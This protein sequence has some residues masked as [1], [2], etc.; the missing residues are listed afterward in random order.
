M[1]PHSH[2]GPFPDVEDVSFP[3]LKRLHNLTSY[4]DNDDSPLFYRQLTANKRQKSIH[5]G[6]MHRF[7][8]IINKL[9]SEIT[10]L[11]KGFAY[12]DKLYSWDYVTYNFDLV[13]REMGL[14]LKMGMVNY[15]YT[16]YVSRTIEKC[17]NDLNDLISWG[18]DGFFFVDKYHDWESYDDF[19]K[20]IKNS[21]G[22]DVAL[23]LV[24]EKG[25]DDD[26]DDESTSADGDDDES[27]SADGGDDDDDDESASADDPGFNVSPCVAV[28]AEQ[29]F[30]SDIAFQ[31]FDATHH[32]C[33]CSCDLV[34]N[35]PYETII[36]TGR[37][38]RSCGVR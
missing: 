25:H 23:G 28:A 26:D 24:L 32:H 27:T 14:T 31:A 38:H 29:R 34:S 37:W 19:E 21:T 16:S 3:F 20:L 8:E 35:T 30:P 36:S 22:L 33:S 15:P 2:D 6:K 18:P 9:N 13:K 5:N 4:N 1:E 7:N 10:W 17:I 12:K 11:N